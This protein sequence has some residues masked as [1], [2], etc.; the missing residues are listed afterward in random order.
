VTYTWYLPHS[1]VHYGRQCHYSMRMCETTL[2]LLPVCTVGTVVM[3]IG[4]SASYSAKF[5]GDRS[6]NCRDM[7]IFRFFQHGGRPPSWICDALKL[8][9]ISLRRLHTVHNI[10]IR[11]AIGLI[12]SAKERLR[13]RCNRRCLFVCL[14][15]CL[16][17][18]CLSVSNFA[19]ILPNGIV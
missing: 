6:N 1:R 10:H 13:D 19:Q 11:N 14:S 9:K 17:F 8:A 2:F 5:C 16:L 7:G 12:T 4:Q 3:V 15:V 18:V